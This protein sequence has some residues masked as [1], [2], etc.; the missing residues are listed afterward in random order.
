MTVVCLSGPDNILVVADL[1][2]ERL[3]AWATRGPAP[4]V[5]S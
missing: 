1:P 5:A 2:A 3:I 4:V